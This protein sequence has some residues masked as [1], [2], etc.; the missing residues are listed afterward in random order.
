MNG[1]ECYVS[2]PIRGLFNL[3]ETDEK[4]TKKPATKVS[5]PIRGLFNLTR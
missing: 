4:I 3:T 5:V 2:V 1:P